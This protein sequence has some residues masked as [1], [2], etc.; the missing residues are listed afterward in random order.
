MNTQT[1]A[2]KLLATPR[3]I[4]LAITLVVTGSGPLCGQNVEPAAVCSFDRIY[5]QSL[6]T[7][8]NEARRVG[9]RIDTDIDVLVK[10]ESHVLLATI[11]GFEDIVLEN[12]PNEFDFGF[13]G[14]AGIETLPDGFYRTHYVIDLEHPED[15]VVLLI[16]SLGQIFTF[17]VEVADDPHPERGARKGLTTEGTVIAHGDYVRISDGSSVCIARVVNEGN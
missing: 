7:M 6:R 3:A 5:Q 12:G 14:V 2:T 16:N 9:L 17:A 4:A 15:A 13:V 1:N 10:T 11:D 8:Q